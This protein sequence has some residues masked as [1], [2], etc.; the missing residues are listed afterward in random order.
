MAIWN[1]AAGQKVRRLR[2]FEHL[3]RNADSG[4]SRQLVANASRY[5]LIDGYGRS[6]HLQ[7]TDMGTAAINPE[8]NPRQKIQTRFDL[9]ITRIS[10]F[11]VLY[12]RLKSN[13]LPSLSVMRDLLMDEGMNESMAS[14]CVD[15]FVGNVKFLGLL[16]VVAGAERLLSIG[17]VLEELEDSSPLR[18]GT[19]R[20]GPTAS[21][22]VGRARLDSDTEEVTTDD[23]LGAT[24]DPAQDSENPWENTCFYITPIGQPDSEHRQHSDLFLSSLVEPAISQLGLR[25]VRADHI[26]KPGMITAQIIEHVI[27][28]RLVVADLSYHNPNV[29][30]ELSLRHA[31]ALPT[32]QIIRACDP[33]PFD[34]D[35]Y[36]TIQIDTSSIYTLVPRL[37][38]YKADIANQAR[39]ALK[40]PQASS[41]P[42]TVFYPGLRM[43]I[44]ATAR[45][46]TAS[47]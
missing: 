42:L 5:G 47:R 14:E 39:Q 24:E 37:E 19:R 3:S 43:E 10:P 25:V 20:K 27:R 17:H 38:V 1:I 15:F 4:A 26:G 34:L 30:Y 13:K 41:N 12:E 23:K 9:A 46:L 32:V 8:T 6:E 40:D 21:P 33:I 18:V 22:N 11:N 31:C 28:A 44:P 2:V 29:F 36:R 45:H 7:L 16:K 35:Q